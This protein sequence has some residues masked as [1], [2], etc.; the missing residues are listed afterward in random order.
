MRKV[1]FSVNDEEKALEGRSH[2]HCFCCSFLVIS[3][4]QDPHGACTADSLSLIA[5]FSDS[6]NCW[7]S[8]LLSSFAHA[9]KFARGM[10]EKKNV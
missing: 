6:A 7:L 8:Q 2:K 10:C 9:N 5:R 4:T 3:V 1:T